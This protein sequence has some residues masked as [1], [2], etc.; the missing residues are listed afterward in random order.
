MS[1]YDF[2]DAKPNDFE[3]LPDNTEVKVLLKVQAGDH[4]LA[5]GCLRRSEKTGAHMLNLE[6][7]VL[8]GKFAKRKVFFGFYL[9]NDTGKLTEGQQTAVDMSRSKLRAITE[10]AR[11][12]SPTDE[13]P[14]A[15]EAR[16]LKKGFMDLNDMEV[17][18]ILGVEK[19]TGGY[20]DKNVL[21]RVVPHGKAGFDA[22]KEA[23]SMRS[24]APTKATAKAW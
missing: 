7:T 4:D 21:K 14:A 18:V 5:D 10:A 9:G 23:A 2:N 1:G 8:E 24:A 15:I 16:K 22:S 3:V 11:G 20:S 19:G 12:F 13:T 6:A 17:S